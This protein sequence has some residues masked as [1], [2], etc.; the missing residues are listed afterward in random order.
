[1]LMRSPRGLIGCSARS[2]CL[3][4]ELGLKHPPFALPGVLTGICKVP[5]EHL[6]AGYSRDPLPSA[7]IKAARH[8]GEGWDTSAGSVPCPNSERRSSVSSDWDRGS[9]PLLLTPVKN[10]HR[11]PNRPGGFS[12]GPWDLFNSFFLVGASIGTDCPPFWK[13][14]HGAHTSITVRVTHPLQSAPSHAP[15]QI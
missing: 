9:R 6:C 11:G 14:N 5:A 1:M 3:L 4:R 15:P 10:C 7:R 13:S 8:R 12:K 2:P